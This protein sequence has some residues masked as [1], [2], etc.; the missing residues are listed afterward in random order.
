MNRFLTVVT[1]AAVISVALL[2]IGQIG[3]GNLI[4]GNFYNM[5]SSD[6]QDKYQSIDWNTTAS[7]TGYAGSVHLNSFENLS[8]KKASINNNTV[9]TSLEEAVVLENSANSSVKINFS[10]KILGLD[11]R[12]LSLNKSSKIRLRFRENVSLE[13][14]TSN[15]TFEKKIIAYK[16][17]ENDSTDEQSEE[18]KISEEEILKLN[19][20]NT[21]DR[22]ITDRNILELVNDKNKTAQ[23]YYNNFT[24]E[25]KTNTSI[26][27]S[28]DLK[29]D[30]NDSKS[31]RIEKESR[32]AYNLTYTRYSNQSTE[33]DEE[34]V[35]EETETNNTSTNMS[36]TNESSNQTSDLTENRTQEAGYP[37][38]GGK[39]VEI[40]T[41][42]IEDFYIFKYEASRKDANST[43]EGKSNSPYSQKGVRPWNQISQNEASD[44]CKRLGDNYSLPTSEQ[45]QIAAISGNE[46]RE[47]VGGNLEK[48]SGSCE[49]YSDGSSNLCK[50]GTGPNG[51]SNSAGAV[52]MVG[53]LWEW[54][55]TEYELPIEEPDQRLGYVKEW[56]PDRSLPEELSESK[57]KEYGNSYFYASPEGT[58]A[59]RKGGG[60]GMSER[61]GRYSTLVDRSPDYKSGSI[62]FRCVY[63]K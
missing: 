50:T 44:S 34:N 60:V 23:I 38:K 26:N 37:E 1:G 55:D 27:K 45:W 17:E 47:N 36:E 6:L 24:F 61:S 48:S 42:R 58:K 56:N 9:R 29:I 49:R 12:T 22:N 7:K 28:E 52:D 30:L 4:T 8:H 57:S 46:V 32:K 51:W 14:E 5:N 11:N 39:W 35:T 10:E 41:D 43:R 40:E 25:N 54:T 63:T 31:L 3:E 18:V 21:S 16:P 19:L 2:G 59:V 15:N 62:G 13:L 53:N 33:L 20:S